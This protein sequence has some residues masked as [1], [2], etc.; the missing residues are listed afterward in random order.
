MKVDNLKLNKTIEYI[1]QNDFPFD[2]LDTT[3][4]ITEILKYF[5]IQEELNRAEIKILKDELKSIAEKVQ[6][7]EISMKANRNELLFRTQVNNGNAYT[8]PIV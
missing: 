4:S 1:K 2:I 8:E 3:E 5:C 6:T 7:Q